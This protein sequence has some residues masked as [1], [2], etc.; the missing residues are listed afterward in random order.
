[1]SWLKTGFDQMRQMQIARFGLVLLCAGMVGGCFQP[2]Y[3]QRSDNGTPSLVSKMSGVEVMAIDAPQGTPESRIGVEIRDAL[4][5]GLSGGDSGHA[6]THR[7]KV[8]IRTQRQQL[9]VDI[10]TAR[11]DNEVYGIEATY[12]LTDIETG[13]AVVTGQTFARVSYDIPGQE[14]RFARQRALRDAENRA[15]ALIA[16]NIKARLASH[17]VAGT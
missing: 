11:P 5:S 9:I 17:F 1:M 12:I 15:A 7:L 3:G 10:D 14:Q 16:D 4:M 2:M 8:Q 6:T 13:K